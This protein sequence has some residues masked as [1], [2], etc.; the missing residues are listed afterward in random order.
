MW[1]VVATWLTPVW[2]PFDSEC[3]F[4]S[5]ERSDGVYVWGDIHAH[6][7]KAYRIRLPNEF[8]EHVEQQ[9]LIDRQSKSED[10]QIFSKSYEEALHRYLTIKNGFYKD[11]DVYSSTEPDDF[12]IDFTK[13]FANHD[14]EVSPEGG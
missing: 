2:D 7:V 13:I 4:P 1:P 5:L 12:L 14:A 11:I 10:K 9:I 3:E 6:L 8:I